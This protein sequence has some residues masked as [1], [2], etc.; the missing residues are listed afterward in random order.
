MVEDGT[1][2]E[3][4]E[5]KEMRETGEEV[6]QRIR[7]VFKELAIDATVE[8]LQ[9]VEL[10]A[11]IPLRATPNNPKVKKDSGLNHLPMTGH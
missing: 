10:G 8:I 1:P 9:D 11:S 3:W 2:I 5:R 7:K 6:L 4:D